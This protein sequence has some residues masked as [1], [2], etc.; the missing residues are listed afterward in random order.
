[1]K[2]VP[3]EQS[4]GMVLCQ[5]ITKI[6]PGEFKGS[7]FKKGHVIRKEDIDPLLNVGKENI[8]VWEADE[9][10]VHENDAA[11][12][13]AEATM[14]ENLRYE[15]PGEGKCS[16]FATCRGL[17][18]VD[19]DTLEEMNMIEMITMASLPNN[20]TVELGQK[21]AGVRVVPLM[22]E[23][24]KLEQVE[25]LAKVG[26]VFNILPYKPLKCGIIT[27][28]S[29]VFKGRIEDKF[30]P[31]MKAKIKHFGGKCIEQVFCPDDMEKIV[32]AI[33]SFKERG[34][35]LIILTGGMSVDPDDVT[36]GAIRE[37]GARVVTYGAPVQPGNMLAV[38]YLDGT[39]LVGVPGCAMFFR[40]TVLDS[41]L[42]RI[43]AG[44]ELKKR[45]FAVMGAGGFCRGCKECTYPR[46]YFCR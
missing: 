41:I 6:V 37:S 29:E 24:E 10:S 2:S 23:K 31:V 22:V 21:V 20:Y 4:V 35:E 36:P 11:I 1:M 14:G 18:T 42:P 9:N 17:F 44:V 40:T 26:K 8:Y 45:D 30:G 27:T 38:A 3:V 19:T 25:E 39:A 13:L 33:H 16:L 34:A 5:D 7:L 46:C 32:A 43:F 28:G 15:A 12:R